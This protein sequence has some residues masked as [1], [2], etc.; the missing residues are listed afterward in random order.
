[1]DLAIESQSTQ[2]VLHECRE[3]LKSKRLM[4]CIGDHA[5]LAAMASSIVFHDLLVAAV[6]TEEEGLQSARAYQPDLV[7]VSDDLEVG[8]GVRFLERLKQQQPSCRVLILLRRES[9]NVVNEALE[10]GADGVIFSSSLGTGHGDF[11][12]ALRAL[13]DGGVYYPATVRNLIHN[14]LSP[15]KLDPRDHLSD[16]EMDIVHY[17]AQGLRNSEIAQ[18]LNISAETVK[19]HISSSIQKLGVR[20]R[21]QLAIQALLHGWITI[22]S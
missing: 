8:Y 20:D 18:I 2:S 5:Q 1:M 21:T 17:V 22:Q 16:R 19:S 10:A 7:F 12:K 9:D 15:S 4:L 6:S 11:V 3:L 13:A 14:K